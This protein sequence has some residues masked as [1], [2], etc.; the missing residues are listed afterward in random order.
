[1]I[2]GAGIDNITG[3]AEVTVIIVETDGAN[4]TGEVVTAATDDIGDSGG[5]GTRVINPGRVGM[6]GAPGPG[7]TGT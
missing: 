4:I 7:N 5:A 6:T 3:G 2:V 1:M